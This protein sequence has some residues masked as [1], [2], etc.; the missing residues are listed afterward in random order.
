MSVD[1]APEHKLVKWFNFGGPGALL[2]QSRTPPLEVMAGHPV[3]TEQSLT[4]TGIVS[5]QGIENKLLLSDLC[6]P[7]SPAH[8]PPRGRGHLDQLPE[9]W[10]DVVIFSLLLS[11]LPA[12]KQRLQCCIN[13]YKVLRPH[14]LLLIVTPDSSHQNRHAEM[15]KDW[16]YCIEGLG[17]HR[18][19][20]VKDTHLHCMAF[21]KTG[22]LI[23][24]YS[25][26]AHTHALLSIP[27]DNQELGETR[28]GGGEGGSEGVGSLDCL[29]EL[30]FSGSVA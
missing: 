13:A 11:Y 21:R 16:K 9:E 7:S 29:T 17:F 25:H 5:L 28:E 23:S 10:Y 6:P 2:S 3:N 1:I 26:L 4:D 30:P 24:D 19:R 20:Y 12:T 27:Q 14:G 15:M 18:W 22:G 8:R